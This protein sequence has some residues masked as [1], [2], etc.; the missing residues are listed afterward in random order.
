MDVLAPPD[1]RRECGRRRRVVLI[2]RRWN[3]ARGR[4][5]GRW[6]LTS[7]ARQGER[8]I[9]R[10]PLRRECRMCRHACSDDLVCFLP[11][12]TRLRV[13]RTPGIPCALR[14]RGTRRCITRAQHAAR[15][16]G[17]ILCRCERRQ[18]LR[19]YCPSF[20]MSV[21]SFQSLPTFS[22]TTTYLPI[23]SFGFGPLVFSLN[24][25]ISRA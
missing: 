14:I 8:A 6:R 24:V 13:C 1:E 7:P 2:P 3:Q 15:M 20:Q 4:C 19:A 25:P 5:H 22:Q 17:R 12:H 10:N 21:A 9:S 11:L 23:T 16:R 18:S